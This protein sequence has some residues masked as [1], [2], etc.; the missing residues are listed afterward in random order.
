MSWRRAP[1]FWRDGGAWARLLL[2]VAW[3]VAEAARLRWKDVEP[4]DTGLPVICIGNLVAGGAGKTPVAIDLLAKLTKSGRRAFALTRGYGGRERGPLL[5]DLSKHG[6]RD[7]GDEALL[8]A[9]AAPTVVCR[10]RRDGAAFAKA[11]GADILVMD[12]GFQN[13]SIK[14][15]LSI[16]VFDGGFGLGNGKVLP[17]GPLRERPAEAFARAQAVIILGKDRTR[18][19]AQLPKSLPVLH[20]ALAPPPDAPNVAGRRLLAFA[21]IGRPQK[22]FETLKA[23]GAELPA[24]VSFPDH[25][26]YR[27]SELGLILEKAR[28]LEATPM[29]TEKDL[30]RIPAEIAEQIES[31]PISLRWRDSDGLWRLLEPLMDHD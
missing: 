19:A 13:P 5:V 7:V 26:P 16:L 28:S 20:A 24:S 17:A 23:A 15:D 10:D 8:L 21:G 14:K 1:D 29:T 6:W 12:D 2:P 4:I 3:V 11:R 30:V 9:R 22:F 18:L 25:H 31:Y 27:D